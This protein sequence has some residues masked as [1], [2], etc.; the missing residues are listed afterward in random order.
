M[1]YSSA[2]G[3]IAA[4]RV[5]PSHDWRGAALRVCMNSHWIVRPSLPT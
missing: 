3:G 5:S 2:L 4:A 1:P